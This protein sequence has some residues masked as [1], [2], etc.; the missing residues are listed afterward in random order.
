M[1]KGCLIHAH[2]KCMM[3]ACHSAPG[4]RRTTG[5]DGI[6]ARMLKSVAT[7]ITPSL[8]RLFN[9]SLSTGILP[10]PWKRTRIVPIP[11]STQ[12]QSSPTNY[13]P[14]SILPLVSKLLEKHVH[15]LLFCYLHENY[16]ISS[17][18]RGFLPGRSAQSALLSVTHD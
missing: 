9:L 18:Q 1:H 3:C 13:C 4:Q 7:S 10:D 5:P 17:R 16:P 8:T 14:I 2:T 6:S 12:N 11:K 15:N